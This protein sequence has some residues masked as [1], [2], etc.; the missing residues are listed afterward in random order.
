MRV[1]QG[2]SRHP[3]SE[4]SGP[5]SFGC[6]SPLSQRLILL[7]NSVTTVEVFKLVLVIVSEIHGS[8]ELFEINIAILD[9]VTPNRPRNGFLEALLLHKIDNSINGLLSSKE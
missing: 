5:I 8:E 6:K 2:N 7:N 1:D 3:S 4:D 9:N